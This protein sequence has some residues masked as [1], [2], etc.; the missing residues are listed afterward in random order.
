MLLKNNIKCN[1]E[2]IVQYKMYFETIEK[3]PH[4]YLLYKPIYYSNRS[5][6]RF[7]VQNKFYES[8]LKDVCRPSSIDMNNDKIE[9]CLDV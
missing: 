3:K 5:W 8:F 2:F 9:K 7:K 1:I 6:S 4:K